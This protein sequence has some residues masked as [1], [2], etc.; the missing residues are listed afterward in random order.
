M[1]VTS[2]LE[3]YTT[4]LGWQ[5]YQNLWAILSGTGIVFLPFLFILIDGFINSSSP[6]AALRDAEIKIALAL[7]VVVL[8]AQ[9]A[10]ELDPTI[11]EY[12]PLCREISYTPGNT[13]SSYDL[14]FA[15][16][17]ETVPVPIWWYGT[18]AI[19]SGSTYAAVLGLDCETDFRKVLV[20]L[21]KAR[22]TDTTLF[23][24]I[25]QFFKDCFVPAR[26]TFYRE[27]PDVDT[28][29]EQ[30]GF[31][32]PE[33]FLSHVYRETPG[34]YDRRRASVAISRWPY[35]ASRDTEPGMSADTGG[36]PFCKEWLEHPTLGLRQRLL[37]QLE[38]ELQGL[39]ERAFDGLGSFIGFSSVDQE[40]AEDNIINTVVVN[41][42]AS[43]PD[44]A[45]FAT[46]TDA[47]G[48][49]LKVAPHPLLPGPEVNVTGLSAEAGT[50]WE[51]LSFA[52][53]MYAIRA[54]IPIV[55]ALILLGIYMILPFG[56]VF[57]RYSWLFI[58]VA[59][60]AIL[61]VY[62]WT[63]LWHVAVWLENRLIVML[64]PSG[65]G[66]FASFKVG[67]TD[68]NFSLKLMLL[69]IAVSLLFIGL[70]L[71]FSMV[72]AWA[73]FRSGGAIAAVFNQSRMQFGKGGRLAADQG[74]SAAT[75]GITHRIKRS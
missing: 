59:T 64:F 57:S 32:D 20:E 56:I 45:V 49:K 7:T 28:L 26:S 19:A 51:N 1:T 25:G 36:R 29:L 5:Q 6:A 73:G 11:V 18:L 47:K 39:A 52:P 22:I 10:I 44:G 40:R 38:P 34:Y 74:K 70:P 65:Q 50:L 66:L 8:V 71:L 75:S 42:V 69:N 41:S 33:T 58:F 2:Y 12:K 14:A 35:N 67:M 72:I 9:P 13:D 46:Y 27:R 16:P 15:I 4:L 55:Q 61:T 43:A 60:V 31:A 48:L 37:D 62:F 63:Y 24:E 68:P 30:Y 17:Q 53:M 21:D 54:G 3:L 23:N